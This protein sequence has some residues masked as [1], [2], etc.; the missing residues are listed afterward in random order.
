MPLNAFEL[1]SKRSWISEVDLGRSRSAS[2]TFITGNFCNKVS[3]GAKVVNDKSFWFESKLVLGVIA[4]ASDDIWM[5][6]EVAPSGLTSRLSPQSD[7][8]VAR[9]KSSGGGKGG[10]LTQ[11]SK[12]SLLYWHVQLTLTSETDLWLPTS[13]PKCLAPLLEPESGFWT[14]VSTLVSNIESESPIGVFS[15]PTWGSQ[16]GFWPWSWPELSKFSVWMSLSSIW[17]LTIRRISLFRMVL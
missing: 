4:G 13:A 2:V 7:L 15:A 1:Y 9:Q 16:T 14:W 5:T 10:S 11:F 12:V 3:F 6:A 8:P 17:R